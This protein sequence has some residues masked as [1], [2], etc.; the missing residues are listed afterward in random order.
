MKEKLQ[1]LL[2]KLIIEKEITKET[3]NACH[4]TK[5]EKKMLLSEGILLKYDRTYYKFNNHKMLYDYGNYLLK[6]QDYIKAS[7]CFEYIKT[8]LSNS[9]S[10]LYQV[11]KKSLQNKDYEKAKTIY[12]KMTKINSN[13]QKSEINLYLYLLNIITDLDEELNEKAKQLTYEDVCINKNDNR[14]Q[15]ITPYNRIRTAIITNHLEYAKILLLELSKNNEQI[16]SEEIIKLLT[17]EAADVIKNDK[18][19]LHTFIE[20]KNYEEAIAKLNNISKK[21]SLTLGQTYTLKLLEELLKIKETN[22]VPHEK[23][24]DQENIF[25]QIDNNN[26]EKALL[27][28]YEHCQKFD[29]TTDIYLLL[30]EIVKCINEIKSEK[31]KSFIE[32][33][34]KYY[35]IWDFEELDE[36]IKQTNKSIEKA[37]LD[38]GYLEDYVSKVYLI[39]AQKYLEKGDI[40]EAK[41][42]LELY[43]NYIMQTEETE[44]IYKNLKLELKNK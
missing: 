9:R 36:Y 43:E 42:Y 21:M 19:I 23:Y 4:I 22:S 15:K 18:K 26:Y 25:A 8:M 31:N 38:F 39:Y 12:K 14:Y 2:D 20:E 30:K 6:K 37:C 5:E 16:I 3:L 34:N 10:E 11:F 28:S 35:G 7:M 41:K 44:E 17:F 29:E 40:R 32:N 33:Y 13:F 24:S 1:K 27:L